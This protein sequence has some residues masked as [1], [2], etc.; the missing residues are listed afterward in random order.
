MGVLS[1]I[2]NFH[3]HTKI[4]FHTRS[5]RPYDLTITHKS[6]HSDVD[7]PYGSPVV[8]CRGVVVLDSN[9]RQMNRMI[10]PTH[11]NCGESCAVKSTI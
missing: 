7:K 4:R 8:S 10:D 2:A 6:P 1:G 5:T 9:K 11:E 3:V